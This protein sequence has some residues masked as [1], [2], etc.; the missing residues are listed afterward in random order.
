MK[1][2]VISRV[3]LAGEFDVRKLVG[4]LAVGD[5][6]AGIPPIRTRNHFLDQGVALIDPR[7][8]RD[9]HVDLIVQRVRS[10]RCLMFDHRL[11]PLVDRPLHALAR[12]LPLT[13]NQVTIG[14]FATGLL[15]VPRS[16]QAGSAWRSSQLA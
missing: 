2:A 10:F 14:G 9:E 8:L 11:R 7:E 15:V 12:P 6:G 3:V 1:P 16:R 13:A 4:F 5:A